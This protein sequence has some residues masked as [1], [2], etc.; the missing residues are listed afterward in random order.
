VQRIPD[1]SGLWQLN[2]A[3]SAF[4][5]PAPQD[6]LIKIDHREPRLIQTMVIVTAGGEEQQL[7]FAYDIGGG[8]STNATPSGEVQS[9][10]HWN[11]AL[12]SS[13]IPS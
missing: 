11:T 10:A 8:E 9:R 13:S 3:R 4:R 2:L 12:S 7:T 5:G 1:F 6:I